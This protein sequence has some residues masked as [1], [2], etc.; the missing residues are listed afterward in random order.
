MSD[1]YRFFETA[2]ASLFIKLNEQKKHNITIN[3]KK[4]S[5]KLEPQTWQILNKI[6][7]K[8]G[9]TPSELCS[10]I[11]ERKGNKSSLASA[12]RVFLISYLYIQTKK[13]E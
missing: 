5:V 1:F 6:A 11:N 7:E 8:Q 13:E 3:G 12:I 10:F 4:T 2:E 9:C